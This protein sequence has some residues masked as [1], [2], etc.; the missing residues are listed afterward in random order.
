[1]IREAT[2]QD[3]PRIVEM[4]RHFIEQSEYTETVKYNPQ[5]LKKLTEGVIENDLGAVF[6]SEVDGQIT[7]FIAALLFDNPFSGELTASDLAWWVEPDARGS[8]VR[9]LRRAEKW[10]KGRGATAMNMVAPNP[11]VGQLYSRLGYRQIE[12]VYQVDFGGLS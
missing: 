11:R 10:A 1:M 7:G 4:G 3:I 2:V 12:N 5:Q 8:G 6:L 9:L